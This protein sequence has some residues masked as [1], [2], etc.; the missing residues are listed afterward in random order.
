MKKN[1]N[2][3][4]PIIAFNKNSRL[5]KKNLL[6]NK[7]KNYYNNNGSILNYNIR[8]IFDE[9]KSESEFLLMNQKYRVQKM[10]YQCQLSLM[11]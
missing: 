11:I 5:R 9:D 1:L 3:K 6:F 4:S 2:N 10:V 8:K 7:D